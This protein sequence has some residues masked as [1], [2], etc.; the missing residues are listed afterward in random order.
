[1][2]ALWAGTDAASR[3]AAN[4]SGSSA[5]RTGQ[6][7]V[8]NICSL[9]HPSAHLGGAQATQSGMSAGMTL[10]LSVTHTMSRA[11]LAPP[12]GKQGPADVDWVSSNCLGCLCACLMPLSTMVIMHPHERGLLSHHE[13]Q[14][15]LQQHQEAH[16][17]RGVAL[18]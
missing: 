16:P 9:H 14:Q 6:H 1:M 11:L 10:T 3:S 18:P 8:K 12:P 2:G 15:R 17:G 13:E 7:D 4:A 5:G